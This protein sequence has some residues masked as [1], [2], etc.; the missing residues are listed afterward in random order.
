LP[1]YYGRFSGACLRIGRTPINV[2][3]STPVSVP[4]AEKYEKIGDYMIRDY[5][6]RP[7]EYLDKEKSKNELDAL[8]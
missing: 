7:H 1:D 2:S 6:E 4:V 8:L 3:G 5:K